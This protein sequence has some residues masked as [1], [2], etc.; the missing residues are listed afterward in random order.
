MERGSLARLF[1]GSPA[2]DGVPQ[3]GTTE[4]GA[5]SLLPLHCRGAGGPIPIPASCGLSG[6]LVAVLG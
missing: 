6:G 3:R 4:R 1:Q 5:R 2:G